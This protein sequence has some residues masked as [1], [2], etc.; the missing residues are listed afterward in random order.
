MPTELSFDQLARRVETTTA[1]IRHWVRHGYLRPHHVSRNTAHLW[2][3]EEIK[4]V[5]TAIA[6]IDFGMNA[7]LAFQVARAHHAD[8]AP[9]VLH[10]PE[11]VVT[12]SCEPVRDWMA[13]QVDNPIDWDL[14]SNPDTER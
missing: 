12:V 13:R 9:L 5:E 11:V 8:H 1:R 14:H 2:T 6:M 4:I 3:D 10:L 7:S